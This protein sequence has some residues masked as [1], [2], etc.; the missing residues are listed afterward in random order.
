MKKILVILLVP[1]ALCCGG[2][3]KIEFASLTHDFE[4]QAQNTQLMHHFTFRN[5]G[6][7]TLVIEKIESG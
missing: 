1:A 4:K 5:T 6:T 7:G 2:V 3:P